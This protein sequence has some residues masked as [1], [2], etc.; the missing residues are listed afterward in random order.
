MAKRES[1]SEQ[2]E[3]FTAWVKSM[4]PICREASKE[5]QTEDLRMQDLLHA[6][7]FASNKADRNKVATKMQKSRVHRRENKDLYQ[8]YE[9]IAEFF[10]DGANRAVLKRMEQLIKQQRAREAYLDGKREYKPRVEKEM[11]P[12]GRSGEDQRKQKGMEIVEKQKL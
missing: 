1:P 9:L 4:E 5:V 6:M 10:R 2:L 8:R 12:K 11:D 3:R 7:E